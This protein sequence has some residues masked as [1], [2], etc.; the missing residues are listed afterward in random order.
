MNF[1]GNNRKELNTNRY[2]LNRVHFS[3]AKIGHEKNL[4]NG[5]KFL[6]TVYIFSFQSSKKV[7]RI[8]QTEFFALGG[9]KNFTCL[10]PNFKN[11]SGVGKERVNMTLCVNS[12]VVQS[13]TG[14]NTDT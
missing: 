11:T 10:S 4:N 13:T 7:F 2:T 9:S 14:E 6:V 5:M 12:D 1:K 3:G 8:A